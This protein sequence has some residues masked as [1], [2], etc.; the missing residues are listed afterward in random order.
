MAG[1]GS[2]STEPAAAMTRRRACE[3]RDPTLRER[4]ATP[5][6]K[7]WAGA[8]AA[9]VVTRTP[10]G[11]APRSPDAGARSARRLAF[12][13]RFVRRSMSIVELVKCDSCILVVEDDA[14][15]R[16]ALTACLESAGCS[17]VV[18]GDG[19][20]ALERL[21]RSPQPCLILLDV[22]MPR[23]DGLA[24][25][26]LLRSDERLRQIPLVSMSAGDHRLLP[27]LVQS[28]LDKPFDFAQLAELIEK[29]C[30]K[31]IVEPVAAL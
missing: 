7:R 16:E 17:T 26:A 2:G 20:D 24:F 21:K 8:C 31:R 28:H 14:D 10:A 18:A 30:P 13:G 9:V 1:L 3:R 12:K 25:A 22:N 29:F 27:P 23:L 11:D 15:L 5:G 4:S 6:S 19:I